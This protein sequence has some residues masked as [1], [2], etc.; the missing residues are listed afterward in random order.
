MQINFWQ[1]ANKVRREEKKC[2][3]NERYATYWTNDLLGHYSFAWQGG[4]GTENTHKYNNT[5]IQVARGFGDSKCMR[6]R[7]NW[8]EV[9]CN[10]NTINIHKYT[11]NARVW[12]W[13]AKGPSC[14][15]EETTGV[16]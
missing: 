5:Q 7:A 8:Q 14:G 10:T 9:S 4:M 3:T 15:G 11:E 6:W 12:C 2:K 16:T 1:S 13:L